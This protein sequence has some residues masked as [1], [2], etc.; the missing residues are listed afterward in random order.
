MKRAPPS[1]SLFPLQQYYLKYLHVK[2]HLHTVVSG[3]A[4][5]PATRI[6]ERAVLLHTTTCRRISHGDLYHPATP[7]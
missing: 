2:Y 6:R 1:L 3:G 5:L 7:S 4:F